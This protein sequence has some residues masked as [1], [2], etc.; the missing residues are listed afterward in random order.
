MLGAVTGWRVIFVSD[1]HLSSRTA[2]SDLNWSA[3]VRYIR[4]AIPD[5]VVHTGDLSLD[6]ARDPA[7]LSY[8]RSRLDLLDVP[9]LAVP[10]NHDVGDNPS[11]PGPGQVWIDAACRDRWLAAVEPDWWA[12]DAD[13]GAWRL[14][15][16]NAQLFGS[17]L[18]AEAEQWAW[19]ESELRATAADR[20]VAL[21]THKPIFAGEA[22]LAAAPGYWFVP[23]AARRRLADLAGLRHI[24]LV[25]SGHI[26]QY[27]QL[28]GDGTTHLW[29]PTTWAVLPDSAQASVG[30]KRS[31]IL[32][33]EFSGTG[34]VRHDLIVPDGLRQL[35]ITADI[36][37]PYHP[38]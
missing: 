20:R 10:G 21:V 9:W 17:G 2:E 26:H 7:D 34:Q 12:A 19:L 25:L 29:V 24:D 8:A 14:I 22:E 1:S 36:P 6:G 23:P 32:A 18:A 30:T 3:V 13:I 5:L 15:G 28:R 38:A 16:V 37:D 27:R 33:V 4:S 31:G 11:D 35:T